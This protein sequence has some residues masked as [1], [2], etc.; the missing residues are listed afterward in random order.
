[1]KGHFN[2]FR[3][4]NNLLSKLLYLKVFAGH[5]EVRGGLDFAVLRANPTKLCFECLLHMEKMH[6]VKNDLA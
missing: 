3:E 6:Q 4:K 1:M 5:I 2:L